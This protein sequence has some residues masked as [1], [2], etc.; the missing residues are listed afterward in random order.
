[1]NTAQS[2]RELRRER[3]FRRL[4][5]V[6]DTVNEINRATMG[7]N[8]LAAKQRKIELQILL[9]ASRHLSAHA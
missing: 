7:A 4:S 9:W 2:A 5:E 8:G 1:M 6:V 3:L